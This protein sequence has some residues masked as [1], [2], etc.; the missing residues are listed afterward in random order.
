M[1][2][3]IN[4]FL[5]FYLLVNG[6]KDLLIDVEFI[7]KLVDLIFGNLEGMILD[8][9]GMV[10][11][12][13]NFSLCYVFRFLESYVNYFVKV[14]FDV[15]SLVNNYFGDFGFLG[16]KCMKEVLDEMGIVYVGLVGMDEIV[17]FEKNGVI[18][19]FCVFVF[20]CGICDIWN[21]FWV[22][23]I[24]V[25]LEKK[26]DIVIVFFYGGVEGVKYCY[27]FKCIEIY[28]GENCGNVYV[29]VYV[30]IDVG[31]DVVFGYGLYVI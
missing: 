5:K 31:V 8:E 6:G 15:V 24:V 19:G 9:G 23:E 22:K 7:L 20:N 4:Y 29:F 26:V 17:V 28:C 21:F 1:M 18:Y 27:V 10:K 16:R 13:S 11:C 25:L 14:G 12:C 3:G 2:F 30:V